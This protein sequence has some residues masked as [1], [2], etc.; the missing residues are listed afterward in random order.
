MPRSKVSLIC[1]LLLASQITT[2]SQFSPRGDL[3]KRYGTNLQRRINCLPATPD[4]NEDAVFTTACNENPQ[5]NFNDCFNRLVLYAQDTALSTC[6]R[7]YALYNNCLI[8]NNYSESACVDDRAGYVYCSNYTVQAYAYCG[9][10][11]ALPTQLYNCANVELEVHNRNDFAPVPTST[12]LTSAILTGPIAPP[13]AT[14]NN[15]LQTISASVPPTAVFS[16]RQSSTLLTSTA[17]LTSTVVVTSCSSGVSSC[18]A[19]TYSSAFTSETSFWTC[20][21]AGCV[22]PPSS[23]PPVP[24]ITRTPTTT[25]A[26]HDDK[27]STILTTVPVTRTSTITSC[28][29]AAATPCSSAGHGYS[30]ESVYTTTTVRTV[31]SCDGG[32]DAGPSRVGECVVRTRAKVESRGEL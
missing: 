19:T 12:L 22:I 6:G 31:L 25:A 15:V 28:P 1:S 16:P 17:R 4:V 5:N 7:F 10:Y 23:L 24:V 9:C 32:C 30:S 13:S 3:E 2:A 11:F 8:N 27:T 18:P 21:S 26:V 20:P 29:A 14:L